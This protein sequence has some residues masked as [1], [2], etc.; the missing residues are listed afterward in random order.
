MLRYEPA[1]L[2][3]GLMRYTVHFFPIFIMVGMGFTRYPRLRM[4]WVILGSLCQIILVYFFMHW[5][6]VS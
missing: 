1:Y 3:N 4:I 5:V 2:L 6:W